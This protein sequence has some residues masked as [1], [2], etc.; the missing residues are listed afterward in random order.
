MSKHTFIAYIINALT[1]FFVS[2]V[3]VI[4]SK[5]YNFTLL[6]AEAFQPGKEL[7]ISDSEIKQESSLDSELI[8]ETSQPGK[9]LEIDNSEIEKESS[10]D[11][12]N[13][14]KGLPID[15][16]LGTDSS[17]NIEYI[18]QLISDKNFVIEVFSTF[19]VLLIGFTLF[20][21]FR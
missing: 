17:D 7:E 19:S 5:K 6:I 15:E 12:A 8:T 16:D 4:L 9:E 11:S 14:S 3:S 2:V 18:K 21:I 10:P 1:L 20:T 13:L